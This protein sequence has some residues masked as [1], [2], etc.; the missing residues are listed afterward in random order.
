MGE[1]NAQQKFKDEIGKLKANEKMRDYDFTKLD[2]I[3]EA[4]KH[5]YLDEY[6]KKRADSEELAKKYPGQVSE[7]IPFDDDCAYKITPLIECIVAV[8]EKD[9][10]L[11]KRLINLV[12]CYNSRNELLESLIYDTNRSVK[13]TSL[14]NARKVMDIFESEDFKELM[15]DGQLD[16]FSAGLTHHMGELVSEAGAYAELTELIKNYKSKPGTFFNILNY[17]GDTDKIKDYLNIFNSINPSLEGFV[18]SELKNYIFSTDSGDSG[19]L[20]FGLG[21]DSTN[22]KKAVKLAKLLKNEKEFLNRETSETFAPIAI[23]MLEIGNEY[24]DQLK[25]LDSQTKLYLAQAWGVAKNNKK[26]EK[27]DYLPEFYTGLKETL[28]KHP[29]HV[30]RWATTIIEC[31]KNDEPSNLNKM[32]EVNSH[33]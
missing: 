30:G 23:T 6:N 32:A 21:F 27:T 5:A 19:F 26:D 3:V 14:E 9:S 16:H 7:P 10:E 1:H 22:E 20:S 25:S 28:D 15:A 4:Y 31:F 18:S 33:A 2:S 13:Q 11:A 8:A 24:R 12:Y 17:W 29:D